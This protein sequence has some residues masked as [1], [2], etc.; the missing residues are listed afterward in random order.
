MLPHLGHL[1]F[2]PSGTGLAGFKTDLQSGHVIRDV[3]MLPVLK[4]SGER[5]RVSAPS[6]TNTRGANA[7]PLTTIYA[8]L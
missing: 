5:G 8:I 7:A 1:T 4:V 2:L 6:E 3:A